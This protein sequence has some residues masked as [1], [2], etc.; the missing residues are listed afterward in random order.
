MSATAILTWDPPPADFLLVEA[1]YKP[2]LAPDTEWQLVIAPPG[3]TMVRIA[4]LEEGVA[5]D[6][7]IRHRSSTTDR[8][9]VWVPPLTIVLGPESGTGSS[10]FRFLVLDADP[11]AAPGA[12]QALLYVLRNPDGT[13]NLRIQA[14]TDP[15]PLDIAVN[16]GGGV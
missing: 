16:F 11:V 6:F 3:S 12:G 4:G 9:S 5:Y 14:G 15:T 7:R 2:A 10:W 13:A 8:A 1:Q